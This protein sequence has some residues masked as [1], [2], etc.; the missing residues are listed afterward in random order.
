MH[1]FTVL[2][3]KG[4]GSALTKGPFHHDL[5]EAIYHVK[6]LKDLR[7]CQPEE[8]VSYAHQLIDEHASS[9]ALDQMDAL[10][11][12]K[13]DE[14]K[15]QTILWNHD[16]LH[17]IVLDQAIKQGGGQNSKYAIEVLELLQGLHQEWPPAVCDFVCE[18]CWLVNF[19]G[20]RN[21]FLPIDMAQEHNIKNIKVTYRSEGPNIQWE[22]FKKLHS[23]IHLI[24]ELGK[25]MEQEFNTQTCRKHHSTPSCKLKDSKRDKV[26]EIITKGLEKLH[27][28]QTLQ[29]WNFG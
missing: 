14:V 15:H 29:H 8:L 3:Q 24:C 27:T 23:A 10:P 11:L 1:A 22:Y 6:N 12:D 2:K 9:G 21:S 28:G 16:V 25:H 5:V 18:H 19:A 4:L 20:Q 17:Y 7:S 26:Q 13:Q